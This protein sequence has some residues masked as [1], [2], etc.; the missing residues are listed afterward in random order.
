MP[1]LVGKKVGP[2]GFG[3]MGEHGP[4]SNSRLC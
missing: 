4:Y 3:L 2:I 1:E